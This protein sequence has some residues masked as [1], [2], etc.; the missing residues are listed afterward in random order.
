MLCEIYTFRQLT[1]KSSLSTIVMFYSVRLI[2]CYLLSQRAFIQ[3]FTYCQCLEVFV[4]RIDL[5]RLYILFSQYRSC[6]DTQEIW[7]FVL[8]IKKSTCKH[9]YV[10]KAKDQISWVSSH[11]LYWEN[12][13]YKRKRS[14]MGRWFVY[15]YTLINYQFYSLSRPF[16]FFFFFFTCWM[17]NKTVISFGFCDMQNNQVL[18]KSYQP[19]PLASADKITLTS[20]MIILDITKTSS[21]NCL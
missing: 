8:F 21:N 4:N 14:I 6:D 11:D 16:F 19:Q 13:M 9:E 1:L 17:Y 15:V 12:K 18:G 2:Y 3:F 5:F 7:S 20:T 10:C